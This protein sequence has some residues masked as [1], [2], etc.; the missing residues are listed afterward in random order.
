MRISELHL[1]ILFQQDSQLTEWEALIWGRFVEEI[2]PRAFLASRAN[3][4]PNPRQ[5][6]QK[7]KKS[8][9]LLRPQNWTRESS[10]N[11]V[12]PIHSR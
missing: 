1:Q 11:Y 12:G 9:F 4:K 8:S 2:L 3:I 7:K 10:N 5:T 6:K